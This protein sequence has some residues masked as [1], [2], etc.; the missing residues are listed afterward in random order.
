MRYQ[1]LR[2]DWCRANIRRV[3]RHGVFRLIRAPLLLD[4][5]S[6]AY[7]AD[8]CASA[9]SR[10]SW[11]PPGTTA[12]VASLM[13]P[14][15]LLAG[16]WLVRVTCHGISYQLPVSVGPEGSAQQIGYL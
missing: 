1:S 5:G 3:V 8:L 9:F 13:T 15:G 16:H 4:P 7:R 11:Q 10:V 14:N 2:P 6:F 12:P